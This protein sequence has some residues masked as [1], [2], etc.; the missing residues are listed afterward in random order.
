MIATGLTGFLRSLNDNDE[1]ALSA[2]ADWHEERNEMDESLAMRMIIEKNWW[3]FDGVA[4]A[5]WFNK[6]NVDS[7]T[8]TP[9]QDLPSEV[10]HMLRRGQ[11]SSR[12]H[13]E[14]RQ[15][16]LIFIA[17]LDLQQALMKLEAANER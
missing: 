6:A 10:F 11:R 13:L 2:L 3:P 9:R 1:T 4:C 14:Y 17:I 15:Y 8:T 7:I 16:D 5:C 12:E